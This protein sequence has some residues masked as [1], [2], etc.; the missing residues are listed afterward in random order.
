MAVSF[1]VSQYIKWNYNLGTE[2]FFKG[3]HLW[4][5]YR[6]ANVTLFREINV[7]NSVCALGRLQKIPRDTSWLIAAYGASFNDCKHH[8]IKTVG[9]LLNEIFVKKHNRLKLIGLS[10]ILI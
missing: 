3:C 2:S 1:S 7:H 6:A 5:L 4:M 8:T 9:F 10:F